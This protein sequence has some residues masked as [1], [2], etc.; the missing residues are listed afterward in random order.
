MTKAQDL[1]DA[2]ELLAIVQDFYLPATL[3]EIQ[4]IQQ[5][6]KRLNN[7]NEK[8]CASHS[9]SWYGMWH[10]TVDALR[11]EV[12]EIVKEFGDGFGVY[13]NTD[14]CGSAI[15]II[16]PNGLYNSFG[17]AECGWRI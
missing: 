17:G 6:S 9:D 1:K 4:K 16:T 12:V 10:K 5:I 11:E 14:P 7:L 3:G 13:F 15:G 2:K 8:C